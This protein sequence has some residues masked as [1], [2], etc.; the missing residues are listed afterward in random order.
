MSIDSGRHLWIT[1]DETR[2]S[3][4]PKTLY[5]AYGGAPKRRVCYCR[6]KRTEDKEVVVN[7]VNLESHPFAHLEASPN[8][9]SIYYADLFNI[10]G[11]IWMIIGSGKSK[12]AQFAT[13]NKEE[14]DIGRDSIAII[15]D[16]KVLYGRYDPGAIHKDLTKRNELSG[17]HKIDFIAYCLSDVQSNNLYENKNRIIEEVDNK[18]VAVLLSASGY[19]AFLMRDFFDNKKCDWLTD[20]QRRFNRFVEL[21]NDITST[22]FLIIPWMVSVEEKSALYTSF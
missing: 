21:T 3:K 16:N 2:Y 12:A 22:R 4:N 11:K 6:D 13:E 10:K 5:H 9:D 15:R 7:M 8:A 17:L 18:V 1:I 14:A 19:P 20:P